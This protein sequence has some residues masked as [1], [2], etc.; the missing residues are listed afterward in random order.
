LLVEELGNFDWA[1]AY[2]FSN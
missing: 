1:I 2:R